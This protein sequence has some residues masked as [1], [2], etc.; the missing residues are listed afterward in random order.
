VNFAL[1]MCQYFVKFG[2]IYIVYFI[3]LWYNVR[4]SLLLQSCGCRRRA[5]L[6]TRAIVGFAKMPLQASIF[7]SWYN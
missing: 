1:Q 4:R 3:N 7:A 2:K 6:R 5:L